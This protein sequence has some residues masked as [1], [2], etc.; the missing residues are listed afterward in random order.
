M[1]R[2]CSEPVPSFTD[3]QAC[4]KIILIVSCLE[5]LTCLVLFIMVEFKSYYTAPTHGTHF[6]CSESLSKG[7]NVQ[8]SLCFTLTWNSVTQWSATR[9][10]V[11][12]APFGDYYWAAPFR[13]AQLTIRFFGR[14]CRKTAPGGGRTR[15]SGTEKRSSHVN[16]FIRFSLARTLARI[17]F[18][19]R[20]RPRPPET[21]K[22]LRT[23]RRLFA[24]FEAIR[25]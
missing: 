13:A 23:W 12:T 14:L 21:Q 9:F 4:V 20:L 19:P 3:T 24:L 25:S 10:R 16:G 7:Y 18:E 15:G 8:M 11:C 17:L 6:S 1:F 2:R 22:A 5:W